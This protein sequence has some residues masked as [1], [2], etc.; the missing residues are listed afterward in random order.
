MNIEIINCEAL[1]WAVAKYLEGG[2]APVGVEI[3][4]HYEERR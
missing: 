4:G 1:K 2:G 3:A